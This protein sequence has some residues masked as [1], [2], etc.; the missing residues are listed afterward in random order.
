MKSGEELFGLLKHSL[1]ETYF[2]LALILRA[3]HIE[4]IIDQVSV[5]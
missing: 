5:S 1:T 2:I 4:N 3:V